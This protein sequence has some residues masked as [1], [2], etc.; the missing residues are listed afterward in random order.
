LNKETDMPFSKDDVGKM[1]W[2]FARVTDKHLELLSGYLGR[3]YDNGRAKEFATHGFM[4]R[5]KILTR[6]IQNVFG[7]LPL[8]RISIPNMDEL[9]DAAINIQAFVFNVFGCVD[10]LAWVWVLEKHVVKT[11]GA[12]L[13]QNQ[14]G[15]RVGNTRVRES[16]S[17][18]FQAYLAGLDDWFAY[19][20]NYRHALA[21]RIPLY[22]PQY[23]VHP[24]NEVAHQSLGEQATAALNRLD[25]TEY[26]R[27]SAEQEAL[28][29]FSPQ[30]THSF[31]EAL[32][33]VFFHPQLLADF[34]TVHE[35]GQKMLIELNR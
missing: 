34:A 32:G 19:Q 18:E 25:T 29:T 14:V 27:L 11:N 33:V 3:N 30:M 16:F 35:L 15:L 10:N 31:S 4:R 21:H 24:D 8:E 22:I 26:N 17:S 12:E 7:I 20:E 2:E 5:I 13:N 28:G 23:N 9:S 1:R 6:C